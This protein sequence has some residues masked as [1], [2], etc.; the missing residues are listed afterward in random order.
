MILQMMMMMMMT[1]ALEVLVVRM[2]TLP[3]ILQSIEGGR[4]SRIIDAVASEARSPHDGP[5]IRAA[6][7]NP[8]QSRR[9][10]VTQ[11]ETGVEKEEVEAA[12]N[13]STGT[14]LARRRKSHLNID[15]QKV[16][17]SQCCRR[18]RMFPGHEHNGLVAPVYICCSAFH[19]I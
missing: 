3:T 6:T 2:M 15:E 16:Y 9:R 5:Q 19:Y 11:T 10:P 1:A 12:R 18:A 7:A 13:I 8:N 14:D 4:R 17:T